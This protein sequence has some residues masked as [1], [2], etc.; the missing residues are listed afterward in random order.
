MTR[1]AEGTTVPVEKTRAEIEKLLKANGAT[2]FVSSYDDEVAILMFVCRDR[3]LRF[4][5]PMPKLKDTDRS[6][7][8]RV[9]SKATAV[10]ALDAEQRRRFRAL[11]L[12]IKGKIES[13]ES[14]IETFEEAFLSHIVTDNRRTIYER[15]FLDRQDTIKM[16][17]PAENRHP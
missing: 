14:G 3:V 5:V 2:K 16:L 9:R 6:P 7:T 8:G 4:S 1:Y 17:P 13:I 11:L 15:L 12:S 10:K